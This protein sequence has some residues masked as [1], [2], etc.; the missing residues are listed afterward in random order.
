MRADDPRALFAMERSGIANN[1]S[2]VYMKFLSPSDKN[3]GEEIF[4]SL[5]INNENF[6]NHILFVM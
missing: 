5:L 3:L 1:V 2:R 6:L 4:Y